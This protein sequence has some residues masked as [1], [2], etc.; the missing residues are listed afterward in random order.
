MNQKLFRK[1]LIN[2]ITGKKHLNV[3]YV[4][5]YLNQPMNSRSIHKLV[6]KKRVTNLSVNRVVNHLMV[7]SN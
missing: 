3:K 1:I 4:L 5:K 6:T 7:I 2:L